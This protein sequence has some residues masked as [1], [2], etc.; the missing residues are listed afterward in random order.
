MKKTL[1]PR[2]TPYVHR[3]G[4]SSQ[5]TSSAISVSRRPSGSSG[6][7]A[8]DWQELPTRGPHFLL[9][10]EAVMGI[11]GRVDAGAAPRCWRPSGSLAVAL[12][13]P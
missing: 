7:G 10:L 2:S 12:A 5:S 4:R 3:P 6:T 11:G 13:S 8:L 9:L 1:P